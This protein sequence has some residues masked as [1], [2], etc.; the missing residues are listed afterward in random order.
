MMD[1]QIVNVRSE[2]PPFYRKLGYIETGT[3]PFPA[4]VVTKLRCH[5]I[6]MSKPLVE[7][8]RSVTIERRKI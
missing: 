6:V 8:G 2:L 3:A 4:E 5:F 1:I 7:A